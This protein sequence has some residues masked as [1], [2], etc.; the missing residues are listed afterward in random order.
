MSHLEERKLLYFG[1]FSSLCFESL[2]LEMLLSKMVW[3]YIIFFAAFLCFE[4]FFEKE[5]GLCMS[6]ESF[7]FLLF[8]DFF[9]LLFYR[10]YTVLFPV[11][12]IYI[13]YFIELGGISIA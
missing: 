9:F 13:F 4:V 7:G 10:L 6:Y 1:F 5:T 2:K 3:G 12:P 8:S 11:F